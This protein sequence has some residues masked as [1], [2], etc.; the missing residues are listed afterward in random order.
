[1]QKKNT[2]EIF[3]LFFFLI[4]KYTNKI[5][6]ILCL[7]INVFNAKTVKKKRYRNKSLYW[8]QIQKF[9]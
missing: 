7:E 9:Q 2:K 5:M 1:M 3:F 8:R 6:L 4:L